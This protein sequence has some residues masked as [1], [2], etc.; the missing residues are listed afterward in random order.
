V[1]GFLKILWKIISGFF[2]LVGT[3]IEGFFQLVWAIIKVIVAL[4]IVG[5]IISGIASLK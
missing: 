5:A 1:I 3:I 2:R 4:L